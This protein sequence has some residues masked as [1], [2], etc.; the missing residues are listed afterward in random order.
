MVLWP[1]ICKG[2]DTPDFGHAFL[3]R[4]YFLARGRFWLSSIQWARRLGGKKKEER[5]KESVVK[6]KSADRYVGRPNG[7]YF[8]SPSSRQL[9]CP[10]LR[11]YRFDPIRISNVTGGYE[12]FLGFLMACSH[13]RHGQD[14]TV[15]SCPYR[16]CEQDIR[17]SL[18][19]LHVALSS[20]ST[21]CAPKVEYPAN[22]LA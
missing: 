2:G 3:N 6:H 10:S 5:K 13:R 20:S 19:W 4:N 22:T 16:R 1:S 15:L 8:T 14:K 11:L 21:R 9:W 17:K 12:N 7:P 18:V